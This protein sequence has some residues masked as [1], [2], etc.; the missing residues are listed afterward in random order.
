MYQ[1]MAKMLYLT[2]CT[3]G[4][5]DGITDMV[6]VAK[7]IKYRTFCKYVSQESLQDVFPSYSFGGKKKGLFLKNDYAV[8]FYKSVYRGKKCVFVD[9]SCIEFVFVY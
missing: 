7:E 3:C 2:N 6:D 9:W 4:D 8:R 5:G 1:S